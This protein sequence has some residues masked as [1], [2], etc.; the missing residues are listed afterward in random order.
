[1]T[2]IDNPLVSV[3]IPVYNGAPFLAEALESVFAQDYPHYEV[4][5]IDDGSTD[6]SVD[7]AQAFPTLYLLRQTNQG[8]SVARNLGVTAAHGTLIAFLDADDVWMPHKL[9]TQVHHLFACPQDG[10]VLCRMRARYAPGVTL[11]EIFNAGHWAGEPSVSFPSALL[12]R[13]E[14][15]SMVGP[16]DPQLRAAE[17][18]DWFARA[19]DCGISAGTLDEVL[20]EKTRS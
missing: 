2:S 6:N 12:V 4:I 3:I 5:V 15:M 20:F 16:F 8:P 1:M 18:F 14:V 13:T 19:H 10:Y 9:S 17:D 7:I 11:P